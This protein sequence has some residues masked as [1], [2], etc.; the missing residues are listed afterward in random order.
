MKTLYAAYGSN[1]NLE[2]MAWR[3]P[4]AK[5]YGRAVLKDHE[6]VFRGH[7]DSAV[8]T[9]EPRE[10][11][12]VPI[13]LWEISKRDERS[14]D[15]YEGWPT[16][17]GKETMTFETDSGPVSAMVYVMTPGHRPGLP[18]AHYYETIA[19]GYQDCGFDRSVLDRAVMRS[20][21]L[22]AQEAGPQTGGIT[23]G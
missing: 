19:E 16:F 13:L 14:L 22:A 18:S 1:L 4:D 8:A 7:P 9:I 2:Q 23:L 12:S 6:M 17:Y 5:I 3:C 15:R 11:S 20:Q 21:E 10:G